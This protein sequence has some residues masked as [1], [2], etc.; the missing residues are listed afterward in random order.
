[1]N[2]QQRDKR[3]QDRWVRA[4]LKVWRSATPIQRQHGGNWYPQRANDL[5][6]DMMTAS[7]GVL[8]RAQCATIIAG[9]SAQM[10]WSQNIEAAMQAARYVTG[11]TDLRGH[12]L[13]V[14][15]T[16]FAIANPE[17]PT[18]VLPFWPDGTPRKTWSF[19][20]A[21]LGNTDAVTIDVWMRRVFEQKKNDEALDVTQVSQ[22][23]TRVMS[24][25][26]R[27]IAEIVNWYPREVQATLWI[28]QRGAA[29]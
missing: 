23:E 11:D 18:D 12:T 22:R 8:N 29:D 19:A 17:H 3:D 7:G 13:G 6:T 21:M 4:G 1:M 16:L 15:T 2:R 9:Y 24:A 28:V 26:V 27:R 5:I 10:T 14:K 25:A 20:Q